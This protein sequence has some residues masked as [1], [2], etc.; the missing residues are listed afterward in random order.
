MPGGKKEVHV[1]LVEM[2]T[3]PFYDSVYV[4]EER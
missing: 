3:Q 4:K 2:A 1:K